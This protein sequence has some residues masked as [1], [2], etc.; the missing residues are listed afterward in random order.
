MKLRWNTRNILETLSKT[1]LKDSWGTLFMV[2]M[3]HIKK[4]K[5]GRQ[6][7]RQTDLVTSS[8]LELLIT[9]KNLWPEVLFHQCIFRPINYFDQ[10][11]ILT[12]LCLKFSFWL[13]IVWPNMFSPNIIALTKLFLPKKIDKNVYQ[14]LCSDLKFI[15]LITF[16]PGLVSTC[17]T[18]IVKTIIILSINLV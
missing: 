9:A 2:R 1:L 8:L 16:D 11:E 13:N 10:K 12:K 17:T 3:L 15:R 4:K 6:T 5:N 7:D 18:C 14:H